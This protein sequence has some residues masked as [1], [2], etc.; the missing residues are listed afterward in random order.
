MRA[1]A[2]TVAFALLLSVSGCGGGAPAVSGA[3][4]VEVT[5]TTWVLAEA[6]VDGASI[7]V[8]EGSRV[9]L[10]IDGDQAGG[11]SACNRYGA[12][13]SAD[14]G[15]VTVGMLSG[16]EM[17]CEPNVM[18]AESTY[19][20]ALPQVTAAARDGE[21]LRLTGDEVDLVF[22][23]QEGVPVEALIGTTW[24]LDTLIDGDAAA[25]P[26][27]EV[28]TLRLEEDG[29]LSGSTGCRQLSG[30]YVVNGDEVQFGTFAADGK[31]PDELTTQDSHVVEVL[32]DGF[33][34]AVEG[35]RLTVTKASGIGLVYVATS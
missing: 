28:A 23:S 26:A 25:S 22:T 11:T 6:T 3:A 27:G 24:R 33:Q 32:G 5:G 1:A 29:S 8:P 34:A 19:L 31:C 13:W 15:R 20:A 14:G 35:D 30:S 18:A 9:T 2:S 12:S 10:M 7:D 4:P 16:T 17:G 21:S